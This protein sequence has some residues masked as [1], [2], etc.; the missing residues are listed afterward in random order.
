MRSPHRR[1]EGQ[2][3]LT[4]FDAVQDTIGF[5]SCEETLLVHVQCAIHQY[6]QI[7]SGR[8][9]TCPPACVDRESCCNPGAR[10]WTWIC[11]T[12]RGFPEPTA[13]ACPGLSSGIPSLRQV[14]CTTQPGIIYRIVEDAL[15]PTVTMLMKILKSISASTNPGGTQITIRTMFYWPPLSGYSLAISSCMWCALTSNAC[16]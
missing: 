10:S 13:Q 6:T 12:S 15:N 16:S 11:W 4:L 3:H 2:D 1:A 8:E 9:I 7:I 14:S 5:L